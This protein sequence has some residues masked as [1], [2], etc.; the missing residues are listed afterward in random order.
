VFSCSAIYTCVCEKEKKK[1][2]RDHINN[3]QKK[4][5]LARLVAL[6]SYVFSKIMTY[7][8][9]VPFL[10]MMMV[11]LIV[12]GPQTHDLVAYLDGV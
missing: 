11:M 2:A 10:L 12:V 6:Y 9:L 1:I 4:K 3:I 7:V 8:L 5:A